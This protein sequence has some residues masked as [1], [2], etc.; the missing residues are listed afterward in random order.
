[1]KILAV[2]TSTKTCSVAVVDNFSLLAEETLLSDQ[3]HSRHL[4]GMINN[5]VTLSDCKFSDIDGFAVIKGP[6]T[7]TGLRIGIS[8]VK[9]LASA[10]DKPVIGISGLNAL[11]MQTE[12]SSLICAMLDAR[13]MEV[14][15]GF[16]RYVASDGK[17]RLLKN[18]VCETVLPVKQALSGISEDC[19]FIG[20]GAIT[21]QETIIE[22]LGGRAIFSP[23]C[24]NTLFASTVA[25][26][27]LEKIQGNGFDT[28]EALLPCYIRKPDAKIPKNMPQK[29]L[30][31]GDE[32]S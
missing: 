11:A 2:D 19:T 23:R 26:A 22:I 21:Y 30:R 24:L 14:Y 9:G 29:L 7:F 13:R 31:N 10:L 20:D 28:I 5:V 8:T 1:M 15:S 12:T 3:T 6:G 16:Y 32:I 4:M 18:E 27:A 17:K 25:Y